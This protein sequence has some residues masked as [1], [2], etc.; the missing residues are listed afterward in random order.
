MNRLSSLG[1]DIAWGREERLHAS[2][3]AY[4]WVVFPLSGATYGKD[5]FR[6]APICLHA[7]S[8]AY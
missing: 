4:R 1:A 3:H 8:H 7:S 6:A 2:G 5:A